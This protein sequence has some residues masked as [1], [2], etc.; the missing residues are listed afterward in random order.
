MATGTG[1]TPASRSAAQPSGAAT[2]PLAMIRD[3]SAGISPGR[4]RARAT[5]ST[6]ASPAA[7]PSA[8]STTARRP[9]CAA[10]AAPAS[11]PSTPAAPADPAR[12]GPAASSEATQGTYRQKH[13]PVHRDTAAARQVLHFSA[14]RNMASAAGNAS[15]GPITPKGR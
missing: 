4:C 7:P 12:P 6:A 15:R 11:A 5:A 14:E 9:R 8:P 13:D 2:A 10:S 1:P 3:H